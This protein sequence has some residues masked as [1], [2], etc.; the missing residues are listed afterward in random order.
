MAQASIER[1]CIRFAV[2]EVD[3]ES[4]ELRKHGIRIKLQQ[5]P[6]QILALLLERPGELVTREELQR[7][8]WPSDVFVDFESGLNNAVK[9]LRAA[10]GDSAETPRFIETVARHGYRFLV[11]PQPADRTLTLSPAPDRPPRISRMGMAAV[12]VVL[13]ALI[14]SIW[15]ARR[16]TVHPASVASEIHKIAVLPLE[17]LSHDDEQEYFADGMTDAIIDQLARV[18]G[19]TVISRTS[20]MLYKK[21]RK[22]LPQIA[23]ELGVDTVVEGTVLRS[24]NRVR[25]S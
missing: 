10:L 22:P 25:V 8:L 11:T 18:R 20:T 19:L 9:K 14:G 15:A 12:L 16:R 7:Q 3:L 23:R 6:F 21:A 5:K 13:M 24:G 4:G 17:S 1:H 2:F